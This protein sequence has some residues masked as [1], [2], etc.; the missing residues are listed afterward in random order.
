MFEDAA[1]DAVAARVEFDADALL[2]VVILVIGDVVGGDGTVI[3][4]NAF[5]DAQHVVLGQGLVKDDMVELRDLAAR[6]CEFLGQVAVVGKQQ[7]ARGLLVETAHR[8]DALGAGI[9]DEF[10]HGVALIRVVGRGDEAFRLVEQDIAELLAVEGLATIHHLVVGLHLV[11]HGGDHF[12]IH[13]HAAGLD[14]VVGFA[15]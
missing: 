2:A 13:L 7:Q 10:H 5:R 3:Q 11:A 14:K 15:A 9:L 6:M 4:L 12:A 1:N 8:I